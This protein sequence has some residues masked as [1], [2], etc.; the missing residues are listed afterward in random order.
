MSKRW[1]VPTWYFFHTFSEKITEQLFKAKREE[2]LSLLQEICNKLPCPYCRDH[3]RD[4]LKKHKLENVKTKHELK[5]YFFKFHNEV[6]KRT[7]KKVLDI[8]CLEIYKKMNMA[9]VFRYFRKEFFRTYY[10]ANHFSGWIRNM[11]LEKIDKFFI[12]EISQFHP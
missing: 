10:M 12:K 1:G 5:M 9:S 3:A 2:C 8:S 7:K 4:Y 6:N 11:L